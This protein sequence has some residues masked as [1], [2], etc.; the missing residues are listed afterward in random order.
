M[1]EAPFEIWPPCEVF[2]I[3]SMLFNSTSAVRSILRLEKIFDE[4]TRPVTLEQIDKLPSKVVLNELHN[5]VIQAGA[6]SRYFWPVRKQHLSRGHKLREVFDISEESP[7]FNRDLRNSIEHFDERLDLY[8]QKT[9][10]GIFLPEYV[11]PKPTDEGIPGHFFRAYFVETSTF[12]LLDEEYE[13]E[14]L[15]N[16]IFYVHGRLSYMNENGGR[17][18]CMNRAGWAERLE[19]IASEEKVISKNSP[20]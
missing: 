12:R 15:S 13:M 20:Q 5:M 14:P 17:F 10:V 6:L 11:G 19:E 2:Y 8:F 7:L 18:G 4:L 16:E 3:H 1:N 9:N